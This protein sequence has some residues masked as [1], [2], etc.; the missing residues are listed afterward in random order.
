MA[1]CT[2]AQQLY[3]FQEVDS[4]QQLSP[5]PVMVFVHTDWCKY[6]LMMEETTFKNE[7]LIR[8]LNLN[9]YCVNSPNG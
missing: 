2:N 1:W 5:R 6:C 9:F 3:S 7:E 8:E 4:L